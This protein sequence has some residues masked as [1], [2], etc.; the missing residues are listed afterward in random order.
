M[1]QVGV[2]CLLFFVFVMR[3]DYKCKYIQ[4]TMCLIGEFR[5]DVVIVT[6]DLREMDI[7]R[8]IIKYFTVW[9]KM[10]ARGLGR[11]YADHISYPI[12]F[13]IV[14]MLKC[15][16]QIGYKK[17]NTNLSAGRQYN[18]QS[19]ENVQKI[20]SEWAG[21][22]V[23]VLHPDT[24]RN[25][26][27]AATLLR[28]SELISIFDEHHKSREYASM[29]R[30]GQLWEEQQ[31]E[32]LDVPQFT[33]CVHLSVFTRCILRINQNNKFVKESL[34]GLWDMFSGGVGDF[35][36]PE[37]Q[38]EQTITRLR[39]A[40][41]WVVPNR[42]GAI[43]FCIQIDKNLDDKK[44]TIECFACNTPNTI[45]KFFFRGYKQCTICSKL[46]KDRTP[47][48]TYY[49]SFACQTIDLAAHRQECNS[50]RRN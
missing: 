41:K 40:R 18:I 15:L 43:I 7:N 21:T 19:S 27:S 6:K 26:R 28:V 4:T 38:L 25:A 16:H 3:S 24:T 39:K 30:C 29:P 36:N 35:Q 12:L 10:N 22:F 33:P 11:F 8:D 5:S 45:K 2:K 50:C 46:T 14:Y 32:T 1:D 20:L 49:C 9:A 44:I 23:S 37:L 34:L 47:C 42:D 48:A 17:S 13:V 31:R